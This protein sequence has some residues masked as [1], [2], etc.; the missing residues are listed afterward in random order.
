[1]PNLLEA[2]RNNSSTVAGQQQPQMQDQTQGIA[3]L[4]RAKS[5]KA[6]GG[7]DVGQSSLGEQQAV[8]QGQQDVQQAAG[9]GYLQQQGQEAQSA[10]QTQQTELQKADIGQQRKFN[11]LENKMRTTQLLNAA[12]QD[13]GKLNLQKDAAA[14]NQLVQGLRLDN[15][16]YISDLQRE[17]ARSRLDNANDYAR[18]FAKAV[19]GDNEKLVQENLGHK[20]IVDAEDWEY[21]RALSNMGVDQAWVMYNNNRASEAARTKWEGVGGA[22]TA[23]VGAYASSSPSTESAAPASAPVASSSSNSTAGSGGALRYDQ[24]V[25]S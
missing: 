2:I 18:E 15:Q 7:S 3:K 10:A 1:M 8:V 17:G 20:S 5:G 6:V 4:L 9:Q 23:A 25:G 12:E 14:T 22:T 24:K 16:K 21:K 19:F 11:A 13:R